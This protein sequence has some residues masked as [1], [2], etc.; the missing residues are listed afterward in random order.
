M[1]IDPRTNISTFEYDNLVKQIQTVGMKNN[2]NI[3]SP[4]Y[5]VMISMLSFTLETDILASIQE[6]KFWETN[7][8]GEYHFLETYGIPGKQTN[9]NE[10]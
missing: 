10:I 1:S 7:N 3:S 4:F 8:N 5:T 9:N 2:L 6:N